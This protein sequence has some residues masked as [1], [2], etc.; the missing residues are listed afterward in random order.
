MKPVQ[1][2]FDFTAAPARKWGRSMLARLA[3]L[4]V[5]AAVLVAPVEALAEDGC[6]AFGNFARAVMDSRQAEVPLSKTL[7]IHEKM[8][9]KNDVLTPALK[10]YMRRIIMAA[11]KK[12]SFQ[13]PANQQRAIDEFV[14]EVEVGCYNGDWRQ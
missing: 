6:P 12:P 2:A 11:Y 1:L 3:V 10:A 9:K 5:S 7:G 14:N 4:A 13:S 8:N